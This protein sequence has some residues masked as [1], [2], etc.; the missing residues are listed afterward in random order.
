M[1]LTNWCLHSDF[2][3]S[4]TELKFTSK[5]TRAQNKVLLMDLRLNG[6]TWG[7]Q[8]KTQQ[9]K[10]A[11]WQTTPQE[12]FAQKLVIELAHSRILCVSP[13][14]LCI[15]INSTIGRIPFSKSDDDFS[16]IQ[17]QYTCNLTLYRM[18]YS[19]THWQVIA[20]LLN[21]HYERTKFKAP[22]NYRCLEWKG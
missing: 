21:G 6:Q 13:S 4:S 22:R 20:Q 8:P 9:L 15:S 12:S 14:A 1:H 10:P 3:I 17:T 7:F 11:R 5:P 18:I 16:F 2:K 19:A